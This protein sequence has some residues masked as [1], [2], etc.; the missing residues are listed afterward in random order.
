MNLVN[1]IKNIVTNEMIEAP[2][3]RDTLL[4]LYPNSKSESL[5][6][7]ILLIAEID[8]GLALDRSRTKYKFYAVGL[9][10]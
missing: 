1:E 7:C 4:K 2:I 10:K 9:L 8:P 6:Q 5:L 3:I